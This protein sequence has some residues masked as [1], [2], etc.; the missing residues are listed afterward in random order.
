MHWFVDLKKV[1]DTVDHEILINKLSQYRVK[2]TELNWFCSYL[3]NRR[4]CCR[5]KGE[6][7]NFEC[8]R[9]GVPQG[10]CLGPLLF[11]LYINDMSYTLKYPKTKVHA[12]DTSLI[13]EVAYG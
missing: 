12:D 11:L 6:S 5:V 13:I 4:Q 1:F 8:I 10:S 3:S 2:K 7:S 9:C